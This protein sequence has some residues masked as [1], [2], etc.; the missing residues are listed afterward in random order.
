V[1]ITK[2]DEMGIQGWAPLWVSRVRAGVV[3]MVWGT[4]I[5]MLVFRGEAAS[6]WQ[7]VAMTAFGNGSLCCEMEIKSLYILSFFY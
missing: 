7:L 1:L 3:F 2:W 4:Y 5:N 6:L